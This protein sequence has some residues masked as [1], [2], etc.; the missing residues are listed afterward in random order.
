MEY[1]P[2]VSDPNDIVQPTRNGQ[3]YCSP[4]CAAYVEEMYSGARAHL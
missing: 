4:G 3:A 1:C 2:G